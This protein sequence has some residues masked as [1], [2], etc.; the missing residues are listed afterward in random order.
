MKRYAP[1]FAVLLST[2]SA[3]DKLY[4]AAADTAA[5][6][7]KEGQRV[8]VHGETKGSGKSAAGTNF[9]NFQDAEFFL[10]TFKSDLAQ[11]PDGEPADAYEG[12]RIAVEGAISIYQGK[13]QIKLS[14]PKQVAVLAADAVFPPPP[15]KTKGEPSAPVPPTA[16]TPPP[17]ATPAAEAPKRKPPVDPS[18]YFKKKG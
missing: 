16:G 5:L 13:P 7:A 14:D 1:L 3:Q 18:E 11:F 4:L 17:G 10:V 15:E 8:V 9:V 12:K 6:V 2:A